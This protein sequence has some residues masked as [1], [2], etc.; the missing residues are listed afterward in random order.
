MPEIL[1]K[2][3]RFEAH[4]YRCSCGAPED[5]RPPLGEAIDVLTSDGIVIMRNIAYQTVRLSGA[6]KAWSVSRGAY[7]PG[8]PVFLKHACHGRSGFM[9]TTEAG[10]PLH[11]QPWT[12]RVSLDADPPI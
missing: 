5:G 8:S 9:T 4:H 11:Y 10:K 7:L 12:Y 2:A 6:V 1:A 3:A